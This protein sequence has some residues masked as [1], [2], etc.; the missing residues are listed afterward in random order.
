MIIISYKARKC[1]YI[2]KMSLYSRKMSYRVGKCLCTPLGK[3]LYTVGK[4]LCT[5]GT[6]LYTVGNC[7]YV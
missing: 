4:C 6:R 3:C 5:P 2:R 1:L 7:L